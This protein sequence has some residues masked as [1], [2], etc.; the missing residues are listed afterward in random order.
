[1]YVSITRW[2][3]LRPRCDRCDGCSHEP[4]ANSYAHNSTRLP[5]SHLSESLAQA[6]R[7]SPPECSESSR[8]SAP[9]S[10][11]SSSSTV[12]DVVSSSSAVPLSEPSVCSTSEDSSLSES[13]NS[14][15]TDPW[16]LEVVP[17]WECSTSG[18]LLTRF[19]GT[20]P[21]GSFV[22]SHSLDL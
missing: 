12:S 8:R 4:Q 14:S 16:A 10:G 11:P 22:Q 20:V 13:L 7:F 9:S 18:R 15:P 6:P 19:R 5:S 17:P 2:A 21:P 3:R 1:M